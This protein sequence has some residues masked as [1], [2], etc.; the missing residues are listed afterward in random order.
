[1]HQVA[2]SVR[3]A[4]LVA[5]RR[6]QIAAAAFDLFR[7]RGFKAVT[8]EQVANQLRID[9]ATLYGYIGCKEDLL[10]LVFVHLIPPL[11]Q[12]L[13]AVAGNHPDPARR[14]DALV[15]EQIQILDEHRDLV[16][17]TYRELRH[18]PRPMMKSVLKIIRAHQAPYEEVI[19][20][21][22]DAG[23][24]RRVDPVITAN[25]LLSMLYMWATHQWRLGPFGLK[26]VS[27]TVK[28]IFFGGV[29][30]QPRTR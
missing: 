22:I 6:P 18:L 29:Y 28:K 23:V 15:D 24:F 26:S 2:T 3:D 10:Y 14:L 9:K 1:V 11:T 19:K 4:E 8:T 7:D 12:R 25:A 16:L 30:L 27:D 17:L 20:N 13:V 5:R 21:G